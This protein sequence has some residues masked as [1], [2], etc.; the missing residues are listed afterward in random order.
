[1]QSEHNQNYKLFSFVKSVVKIIINNL[2]KQ[3]VENKKVKEELPILN[4]DFLS[5]SL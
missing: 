5:N 1:M 2:R 4:L 3:H